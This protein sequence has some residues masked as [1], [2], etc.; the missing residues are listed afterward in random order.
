MRGTENNSINYRFYTSELIDMIYNP[1]SVTFGLRARRIGEEL[2]KKGGSDALFICMNMMVD[3][4]LTEYS[5]DYLGCLREL[6]FCWSGISDDFQ[7]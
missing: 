2:H 1:D 4:L 6:E 3:E 5:K 7:S